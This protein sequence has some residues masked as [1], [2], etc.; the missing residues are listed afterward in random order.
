MKRKKLT[1]VT[2]VIEHNDRTYRWNGADE[3]FEVKGVDEG[4]WGW[5]QLS[6]GDMVDELSDYGDSLT[7]KQYTTILQA[8]IDLVSASG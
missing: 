5:G 1:A 8:V 3:C 4:E 6:I 2:E 7:V